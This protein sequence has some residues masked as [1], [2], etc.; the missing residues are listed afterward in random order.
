MTEV[1]TINE[2]MLRALK[3]AVRY[4]DDCMSGLNRKDNSAIADSLW[5]VGAEI[6]YALFLLSITI[7]DESGMARLNSNFDFKKTNIDSIMVDLKN[8]LAEA[9]GFVLDKKLLEAYE[10]VYVAR[11]LVL[12]VRQDLAKKKREML[13]K[14]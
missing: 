7:S 14:K 13:K 3:S 9:E 10:R 1:M 4:V 5:H 12:K 8:L 2:K 6:E 11:Q